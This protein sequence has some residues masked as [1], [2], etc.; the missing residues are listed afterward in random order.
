MIHLSFTFIETESPNCPT[1]KRQNCWKRIIDDRFLTHI[2]ECGGGYSGARE[3][4]IAD[5]FDIEAN[6]YNSAPFAKV[7]RW[8]RV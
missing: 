7:R 2:N 4:I 6:N 3:Q 8:F 5:Y 1:S